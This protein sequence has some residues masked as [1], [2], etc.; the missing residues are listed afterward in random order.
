MVTHKVVTCGRPE[1]GKRGKAGAGRAWSREEG[2]AAWTRH[3]VRRWG[4]RRETDGTRV[5]V[6]DKVE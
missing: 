2:T 1:M 4:E 3:A 5:D 6:R